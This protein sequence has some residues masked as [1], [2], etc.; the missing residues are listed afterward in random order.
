MKNKKLFLLSFLFLIS[1]ANNK[2]INSIEENKQLIEE[3]KKQINNLEITNVEQGM[4][5]KEV[6][7]IAKSC[8]N[9]ELNKKISII[10]EVNNY[11]QE[12]IKKI[13]D[14]NQNVLFN[15]I[16]VL[17]GAKSTIKLYNKELLIRNI[18]ILFEALILISLFIKKINVFT[19][20]FSSVLNVV[21]KIF[22]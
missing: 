3:N 1:C 20:G 11:Q 15:Q 17:E 6:S 21:K 14:V 19:N 10:V 22:K 12:E 9:E 7:T 2:I 13:K 16:L 4:R 8:N 5:I 18:I